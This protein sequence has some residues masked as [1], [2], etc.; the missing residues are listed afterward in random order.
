MAW[1]P[2]DASIQE[3][4]PI[5]GRAVRLWA[6]A[7]PAALVLLSWAQE[8]A[9]PLRLVSSLRASWQAAFWWCL[10]AVAQR[11]R[12]PR[13]QGWD[14]NGEAPRSTESFPVFQIQARNRSV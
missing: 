10:E 9:Q 8:Q 11:A 12:A 4:R 7:R 5:A 6:K 14:Q 2:R 3:I 13:R 1:R